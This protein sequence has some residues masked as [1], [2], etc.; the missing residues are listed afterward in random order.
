[1][2]S[3]LRAT[4]SDPMSGESLEESIETELR[5]IVHRLDTLPATKIDQQ[6]TEQV[7]VAANAVAQVTSPDL[8]SVP[9]VGPSALAAQIVVLV[10]DFLNAKDSRE[11]ATATSEDAAVAQ[12][13]IALRRSLP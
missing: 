4:Y 2:P 6:L 11:K 1:M 3:E 8:P 5:R 10:R 9:A 13:L 7:R 12:I